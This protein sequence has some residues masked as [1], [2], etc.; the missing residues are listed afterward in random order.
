MD[1]TCF[2]RHEQEQELENDILHQIQ[3]RESV[4]A[5]Q[6]EKK[7]DVATGEEV[8]DSDTADSIDHSIPLRG[9]WKRRQLIEKEYGDDRSW[10][11]IFYR[12]F[13]TISFPAVIW[14][15]FVYGAQ[16]MWL[17]LLATTQSEIYGAEPYNFSA[18]ATGLTNFG[19]LIGSFLGMLTGP[20]VDWLTIKLAT[21]NKGIMEPEFRIYAMILPLIAN[22][23]GLLAYGLG[24]WNQVHWAVTVVVGQGCLGFAMSSS[25]TI[26][27]TYVMDC[28]PKMASECLVLVLFIRNLIGCGFTFASQPW[29]DRD[30]LK[31]TTW[32][33]FM[34]SIVINGSTLFMVLFGKKF[35]KWTMHRYYKYSDPY[36]GEFFKTK[37]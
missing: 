35:R 21:R 17:S 34:L 22:A 5:V 3:S 23:V 26:C 30:G 36:F 2:N 37:K 7:N 4:A 6:D 16:M 14:C 33:L 31:L 9:Y 19:P 20:L 1:E 27:L 32:L 28:Y 29:L 13:F 18:G 8:V 12:P 11:T 25:G 10:L 24:A 15:G